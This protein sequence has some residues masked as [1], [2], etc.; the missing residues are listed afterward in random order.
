METHAYVFTIVRRCLR[1]QRPPEDHVL[2][3][4]Q[5]DPMTGCPA[6]HNSI[7]A[8]RLIG[9]DGWSLARCPFCNVQVEPRLRSAEHSLGPTGPTWGKGRG[10]L[11]TRQREWLDGWFG[12][13]A[14]NEERGG[15]VG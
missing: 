2:M 5:P 3:L 13:V 9:D 14:H 11:T 12:W 6:D 1:C 15:L 10:E 8:K 7:E 4:H